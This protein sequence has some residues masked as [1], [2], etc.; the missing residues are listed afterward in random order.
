MDEVTNTAE[1]AL[2]HLLVVGEFILD[3]ETIRVW[4]GSKPLQLSMKQFRLIEVFMQHPGEALPRRALKE[5]VW[6]AS[7]TIE[8]S[9][10]DAEIARLRR[11]IGGRQRE[12]PIRTVRKLG[13]VFQNPKRRATI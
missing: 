5:R 11:A 13:Y 8:E 7:S 1:R 3:R 10:V 2:H 9:T 4:R 12:A 6:G